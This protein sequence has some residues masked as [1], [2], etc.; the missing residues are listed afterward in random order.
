MITAD[1]RVGYI[2]GYAPELAGK[3]RMMPLP[4]FEPGDV[5][6]STWGGTMIGIT[7]ASK[8]PEAAWKLIEKLYFSKEGI[9]E[10]RK[11]TDIL[12]PITTL[13]S[14]PMFH[15]P[16]PY[17]GG[18]KGQELFVQLAKQLPRRY[19]TPAT[20]LASMELTVVLTKAVS[21]IERHGSQG[22][23]AQCQR[24]LNDSARGLEVRIKQ[25]SYEE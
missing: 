5:P 25:W 13:W 8:H 11:H 15:Q 23:E 18:Q 9:A 20:N 6:T 17:F 19:V 22:L 7:K 14:D 4:I 12:P 2:K 10:R 16:D 21:Y 24:W 3:M 1:W